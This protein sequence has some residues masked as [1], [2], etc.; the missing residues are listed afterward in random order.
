MGRI[1]QV[2]TTTGFLPVT[3][4]QLEWLKATGRLLDMSQHAQAPPIFPESAERL[5]GLLNTMPRENPVDQ[6]DPEDPEGSLVDAGQ[7]DPDPA[8]AENE[9]LTALS[10]QEALLGI[11]ADSVL[12]VASLCRKIQK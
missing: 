1:I 11:I 8:A 2:Q 5:V 9:I 7:P 4:E 6:V 3:P 12:E 10:R